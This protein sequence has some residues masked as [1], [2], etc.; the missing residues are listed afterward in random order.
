[1][2]WS[3]RNDITATAPSVVQKSM[4]DFES[5]I[6]ENCC[7][8]LNL[9]GIL[10]IFTL[11]KRL[12]IA[13]KKFLLKIHCSYPLNIYSTEMCLSVYSKPN[14]FGFKLR[15]F[16]AGAAECVFFQRDPTGQRIPRQSYR[17]FTHTSLKCP[18]HSKVYSAQF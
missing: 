11:R 13:E 14:V 7:K 3:S 10:N 5:R 1:M 4:D 16:W 15:R 6:R 12:K 18:R 8:A 2:S 9:M 17:R